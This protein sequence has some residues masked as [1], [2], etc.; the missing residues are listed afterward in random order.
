ML[1]S[2]AS[3]CSETF[4][5]ALLKGCYIGKARVAR[6]HKFPPAAAVLAKMGATESVHSISALQQLTHHLGFTHGPVCVA[7]W[8]PYP[9]IKDL[10]SPAAHIVTLRQPDLQ[11][12]CEVKYQS[13]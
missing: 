5:W 13:I 2:T 8:V 10:Q 6:L 4:H 7:H 3:A 9:G 12:L 11:T 1:L